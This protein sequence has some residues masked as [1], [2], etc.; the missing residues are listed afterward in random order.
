M[1][2]KLTKL[3]KLFPIIVGLFVTINF[4]PTIASALTLSQSGGFGISGTITSPPPTT[5]ATI[6]N[7]TNGQSFTNLAVLQIVQMIAIVLVLIYLLVQIILW[8]RITIA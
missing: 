2:K 8:L 3:S 5:A 7:P 1:F 6:T 4:M